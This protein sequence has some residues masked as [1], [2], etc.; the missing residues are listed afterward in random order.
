MNAETPASQV[1]PKNDSLSDFIAAQ[2]CRS[3]VQGLPLQGIRVLDL[4]TVI[5]APFAAALLGDAGA[6]VIKIE[7]PKSP[8]ALRSWATCKETGI[9]PFHAV[10]G[11]NKFPVTMNLKSEDGKALFL[12]LIEQSDVLIE[13]MRMGAMER[14]GLSHD[15]LL[16]RNPGLIIG[17]VTGYGMTGPQA[18]QPG[19]G[20]L[21]EAFS[22]FT[23]LNGCVDNGPASPPNPLADMTTGVHLAY[24]ISLALHQ[25]ERGV[26]GG[27][28]ID[29]SLYEP[30]FGYLGGD[31]LSY[32]ISGKN[33]EPFRN[34]LRAAAPRNIYKTKDGGW[35]ALSCSSQQTWEYLAIAMEQKSLISDPRF[36]TNN[37]RIEP[38]NREQLNDIIQRWF[39]EK[40][41]I[42]ALDILTSRGVTAGPVM[43]MA[44]IDKN[45]H[46]EQRGT[47][48]KV[49]DP[50][51]GLDLKIPDV[52]Y[53]MAGQPARI[54][55]PGLPHGSANNAVYKDLLGYD[56]DTLQTLAEKN[57][58]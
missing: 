49:T 46:F 44:C 4:S 35:V 13:N 24:A 11:R 29:I 33:P 47:F 34:E 10:I 39:L 48:A 40:T 14:L 36:R 42:E 30:L 38:E 5:A 43:T 18:E 23:H 57:A 56:K 27:Q 1:N 52:P 32:K 31:F 20:T 25:Q 16:E 50:V 19:F 51:S 2:R 6:E 9:E 12:K 3:A 7:N 45:E 54:R 37:D 22:G 55:F 53:R 8:D 17:K 21:A 15:Y 28:V 41:E 58:I 26:K